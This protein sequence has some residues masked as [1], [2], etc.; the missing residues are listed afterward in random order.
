MPYPV[1]PKSI[2]QRTAENSPHFNIDVLEEIIQLELEKAMNEIGRKVDSIVHYD[3][4]EMSIFAGDYASGLY[5]QKLATNF[6]FNRDESPFSDELLNVARIN[7]NLT[8]L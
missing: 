7:S 2:T 5:S 3:K 1:E 6:F 4:L 8:E